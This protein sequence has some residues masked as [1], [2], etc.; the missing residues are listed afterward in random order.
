M[1]NTKI[2]HRVH[3][4]QPFVPVLRQTSSGHRLSHFF[5]TPTLLPSHLCT[6]VPSGQYPSGF[7]TRTPPVSLLPCAC[8]MPR[9]SHPLFHPPNI[10]VYVIQLE[11]GRRLCKK[12]N[13]RLSGSVDIRLVRTLSKPTHEL[14]ADLPNTHQ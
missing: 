10:S 1:W 13:V 9:P 5:N 14:T 12:K 6:S 11:I 8:H 4:R 3:K 2:H 7:P